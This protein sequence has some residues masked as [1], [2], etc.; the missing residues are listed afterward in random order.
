M[1]DGTNESDE[2]LP[3]SP[4]AELNSTMETNVY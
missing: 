1:E 2:E 4:I 3:F